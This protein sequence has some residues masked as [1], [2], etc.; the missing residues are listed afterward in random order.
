MRN[1]L[2]RA[3]GEDASVANLDKFLPRIREIIINLL[4]GLKRK[5][6]I[7]RLQ[8]GEAAAPVR[9]RRTDSQGTSSTHGTT[10]MPAS[11]SNHS[12]SSG[13]SNSPNIH[14]P[15]AAPGAHTP[16]KV[17]QTF[18]SQNP[19]PAHSQAPRRAPEP[20]AETAISHDFTAAPP[21]QSS[22]DAVTQLSQINLERR[23]SKRF[24]EN[25]LAKLTSSPTLDRSGKLSV[26]DVRKNIQKQ[27]AI[28]ESIEDEEHEDVEYSASRAYGSP[29]GKSAKGTPNAPNPSL[30]SPI[31]KII[32]SP[33]IPQNDQSP[34]QPQ[35]DVP[36]GVSGRMLPIIVFLRH[37]NTTK[38]AS[39]D[40]DITISRLKRTAC[41]IYGIKTEIL[42]DIEDPVSKIA[43]E[44]ENPHDI[45][46]RSIVIIRLAP[47]ISDQRDTEKPDK[48]RSTQELSDLRSWLEERFSGISKDIEALRKKE[49][50]LPGIVND[51]ALPT[52]E[53]VN[54]D[55]TKI[56][57][58]MNEKM[59]KLEVF[60]NELQE[61][62]RQLKTEAEQTRSLENSPSNVSSHREQ[63]MT[64]SAKHEHRGTELT[65]KLEEAMNTM[66]RIRKDV[67]QRKVTPR[68]QQLTDLT[69]DF[70]DIRIEA[71]ALAANL[72]KLD[73][74]SNKLWEN[75]LTVITTEQETLDYQ[76]MFLEDIK[77]DLEQSL[78]SLSTIKQVE[79]QKRVT[80]VGSVPLITTT[81]ADPSRV[82]K[83]V[84]ADIKS[85]HVNHEKRAAAIADAD[86]QRAKEREYLIENEFKNE[87]GSFVESKGF[88]KTGGAAEIDRIRQE[89]DEAHRKL[90]FTPA[91]TANQE[92]SEVPKESVI[93]AAVEADEQQIIAK[94]V[95]STPVSSASIIAKIDASKKEIMDKRR[96]SMTLKQT[97]SPERPRSA[98]PI[99][100]EQE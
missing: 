21:L 42:V 86:K 53:A 63:V 73:V 87:L 12:V 59:N 28:P 80:P 81:V 3:L 96:T 22:S 100:V 56:I 46:Q 13:R 33:Q 27:T 75:E 66:E 32:P 4:Q 85:L 10:H 57:A 51:A 88:K 64:M 34:I 55:N 31:Y 2:E 8:S 93:I 62:N 41:E 54:S 69:K 72:V 29:P 68:P 60:N 16:K 65:A 30:P 97:G 47:S 58:A 45:Q 15:V 82:L 84:Q 89:R 52:E 44:L 94:P 11:S 99:T 61:Q 14:L 91:T 26:N 90:L 98:V 74:I 25:Y 18:G 43:Y 20:L 1:I 67:L 40:R 7:H 19:S 23:S 9:M 24:S 49:E 92:L 77:A 37:N 38:K 48:R 6:Q 5:Q 70:E 79:E 71:D 76:R 36:N 50:S 78:S 17:S 39:F 83:F 95:T 35:E